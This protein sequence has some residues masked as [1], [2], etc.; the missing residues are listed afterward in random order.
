MV[1]LTPDKG[2]GIYRLPGPVRELCIEAHQALKLGSSCVVL[3][4][5]A[6]PVCRRNNETDAVPSQGAAPCDQDGD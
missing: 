2:I 6:A 3:D 1:I 4:L 5:F